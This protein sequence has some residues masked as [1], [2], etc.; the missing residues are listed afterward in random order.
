MARKRRKKAFFEAY[1]NSLI[2]IVSLCVLF[3]IADTPFVHG[4]IE[5]IASL[6]LLGSMLAGVFFVSVFTVA[7]STLVLL[8]LI[9]HYPIAL[10]ALTA[11][12]GAVLGDFLIFR[13]LKDGVFEELAP[14]F[15][16]AGGG[17]LARLLS[18]PGFRWLAPVLG[19]VIIASPFPD[20]VGIALMGASRISAVQFFALTY[21]LN[22]IGIFAI[23]TVLSG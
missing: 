3:M 13:F 15:K 1:K 16:K 14:L 8:E 11:G 18:T 21:T 2:L 20:E 19:A 6:N 22:T 7:P 17:V 23:L 12:L 10:A 9:N 5:R 4:L